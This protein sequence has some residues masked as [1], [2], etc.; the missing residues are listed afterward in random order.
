MMVIKVKV[1]VV[2]VIVV[3]VVVANGCCG[4][5]SALVLLVVVMA[6]VVVKM[7]MVSRWSRWWLNGR[8]WCVGVK[9]ADSGCDRG[10]NS[11]GGC[12]SGV[13]GGD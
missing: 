11:G 3:V 4:G 2:I 10:G 8:R 6:V 13:V 1:V 9:E 7:T 12:S 5:D